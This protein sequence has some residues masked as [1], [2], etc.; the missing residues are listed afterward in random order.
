MKIQKITTIGGGTGSFNILSGL[1][2]YPV[3]ISAIV[4]MSDDGGSSGILRDEL[5]VLP[6]GDA[7]QC[8]VSLSESSQLLRELFNYRYNNGGLKGH[9]FGNIFLSTLE[10]ITGSFDKA[11]E[12]ASQIL[13]IKGEVIPVT[14]KNTKLIAVLQSGKKIIGEHNIDDADISALKTIKLSPRPNANPKA[15]EAIINADKIVVN[16]GN[17]FCSII[18]NFLVKGIAEAIIKS[19]A[20]KIYV[21]NLMTKLGHTQN[22]S[23]IGHLN[24]LEKYI[25]KNIIDYLIFNKENPKENLLKKYSKKGEHFVDC[26]NLESKV[27]VK[28]ISSGLLSHKVFKQLKGD[29]IERTL[30]RHDSDK[31]AK[32]IYEL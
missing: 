31:I 25:K 11:V 19:K 30:I 20:E 18:P 4:N 22:L 29:K 5:G 17:L 10:K 24:E 14:L 6:P 21:C 28:F 23:V 2:S 7:R 3:E 26:K 9:N 15:I 13:R 32:I 12:N 8:L 16:P 1:K 27:K